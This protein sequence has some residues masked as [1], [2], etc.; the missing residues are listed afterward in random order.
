MER[1]AIAHDY[2][3][4]RGGAEKVVLAMA[5]AFPTAPIYTLLYEPDSTFPEFADLDIRVSP[6]N[7]VGFFRRHHRA[8]LPLLAL[9]AS[10]L[11]VDA[12]VVITS[13]SGWAHGFGTSGARITYCYTPARWLYQTETYLGSGASL[14]RRAVIGAL[15]PSLRR[16][17]TR[18]AL[19]AGSYLAISTAVQERITDTYGLPS[20]V[21]PAPYAVDAAGVRTPVAGLAPGFTLCVSRLLPYKNVDVV[22]DAFRAS[23]ERRLVVVGA[24]PERDRLAATLPPNVTL[25]SDVSDSD[26]RWL[27]SECRNLVA[28]SYEDFGLTPIEAAAFGKPAIV[29]RFGGFLD[30]VI[31]GETGV[32]FDA[33]TADA[34]A[35][36]LATAESRSWDAAAI[37]AST[38]R[39][40]EARFADALR[41][42]VARFEPVGAR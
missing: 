10:R 20:D 11:R 29:L 22:V 19:G 16:W 8:A 6:L 33:P 18:A 25:L 15:A 1:I 31:E 2:L 12:E 37:A 26:L 14:V 21:V 5:R 28:A 23:P 30:T 3:T 4:Q 34:V 13:T 36:A 7:R 35:A 32:F 24:G 42:A 40:S 27:Y 17:D 41:A 38:E 39:F 9:A